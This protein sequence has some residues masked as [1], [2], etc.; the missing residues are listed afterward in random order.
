M[1]AA[2]YLTPGAEANI[3]GALG[4]TTSSPPIATSLEDLIKTLNNTMTEASRLT[5]EPKC[6]PYPKGVNW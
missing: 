4:P 2:N 3:C 5:L 6:N 1:A